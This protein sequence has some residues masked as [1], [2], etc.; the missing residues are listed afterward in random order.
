LINTA[1]IW[2]CCVAIL[3]TTLGT[4][5][6]VSFFSEGG[7]VESLQLLHRQKKLGGLI[8]VGAI[9][10]LPLFFVA[11]RK[12]KMGFASGIVLGC[13]VLVLT[14]ALLKLN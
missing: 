5:I 9:I 13:L 14:V 3:A 6:F 2:G 12:N 10:N 8:S 1:T 4:Y 7:F 11:L